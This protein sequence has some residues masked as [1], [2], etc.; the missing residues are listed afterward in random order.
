LVKGGNVSLEAAA[1]YVVHEWR[2]G[3]LGRFLLDEVSEEALKE[4][5]RAA[6]EPALSMNQARKKEKSAR[7]VKNEMKRLG[8]SPSGET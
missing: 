6:E 1:E 5:V 3:G 8:V 4:A 7:K 2:K